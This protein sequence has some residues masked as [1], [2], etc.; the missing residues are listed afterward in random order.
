MI[1]KI[2]K[3]I[4]TFI[5]CLF[6]CSNYVLAQDNE[7]DASYSD[8]IILA[9][10]KIENLEETSLN[11]ISSDVLYDVDN[12]PTYLLLN[13]EN[14]YAIISK[15]HG[16]ISEYCL[17]CLNVPYSNFG[18]EVKYYAGAFNYLTLSEMINCVSDD[19]DNFEKIRALNNEFLNNDSNEYIIST[20]A[21]SGFSGISETRM[22]RYYS[23]MWVNNNNNYP[24]SEGYSKNGIC[25]TIAS[26]GL[27]AY[28]DDYVNDDYV[29]SSIRTK[30]SSSPQQ[31]IKTL[32]NYID[33]DLNGTWPSDVTSGINK[34]LGDYSYVKPGHRAETSVAGIPTVVKQKVDA[35]YPIVVSL[36][37]A[38]GS[39]YKDHW[40]LVY[41]YSD[42]EYKCV[43]NH[44]NYNATVSKVW[45][46][47]YVKL[48]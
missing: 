19:A 16:K 33:K 6:L 12:Q 25:G 14:G 7:Y 3:I 34:F 40:I 32:F 1:N 5:L 21:S 29:P 22:K 8:S 43:D 44:G 38:F 18:D 26:A 47:S 48:G 24:E 28:Y 10:R 15:E 20:I 41:Q 13:F 36:L 46:S 9:M 37:E 42:D 39:Q 30:G 4:T 45:A 23:G 11:L 31:L 2:L 17:N 27:L 35:G